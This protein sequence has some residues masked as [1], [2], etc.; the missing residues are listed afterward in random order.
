MVQRA[1]VKEFEK[2]SPLTEIG[3][4]Q[5][6]ATGRT[7]YVLKKKEDIFVDNNR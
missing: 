6:K 5:A 2:D 4:F 3:Q 7:S 1:S